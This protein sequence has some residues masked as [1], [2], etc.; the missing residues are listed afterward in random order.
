[1]ILVSCIALNFPL[2]TAFAASHRFWV[3]VFVCFK[4]CLFS[5]LFCL[6]WVFVAVRWLSLVVV[7]WGYSSFLCMGFSLQ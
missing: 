1:M 7:S 3:F 2:R 4:I 6:C 5:Y